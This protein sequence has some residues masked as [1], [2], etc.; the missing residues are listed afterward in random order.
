[1][2]RHALFLPDVDPDA[3]AIVIEGEEA[4][5]ARKARRAAAGERIDIYNGR[6]D[7]LRGEIVCAKRTLD[8]RIVERVREAPLAPAIDAWTAAPKGPR[9]DDMI[10]ALSQVGA[11]SWTPMETTY[12]VVE[13]RAGKL[14]RQERIAREACKQ[15]GRAWVMTIGA[16]STFANALRAGDD[17]ALVLA[18][19]SGEP[20][21]KSG[22]ARVRLLIGPEGGWTTDEV[23]QA[24]AAGAQVCSFGPLTM[25]IEV[26]APVAA[27]VVMDQER[28]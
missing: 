27:A 16:P 8:V 23:A 24:R 12:S 10:D 1:M 17:A 5:H 19:A 20:Y 15:C 18:D 4:E 2:A 9:L 3:D 25:R 28:G 11:A 22:A 14:V 7:V 6:G 26:A 21:R 13:P